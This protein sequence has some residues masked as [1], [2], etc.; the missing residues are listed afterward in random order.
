[1]VVRTLQ[2][3]NHSETA[4]PAQWAAV[5]LGSNLGDRDAFLAFARRRLREAGFGWTL[6]SPI[7]ETAPVGGPSGQGAY[8]NQAL[9]AP[10]GGLR[11]S[12]RELLAAALAIESEAGRRRDERWGPRTLDVDLL[13]YGDCVID[14]PDLAVPHPRLAGRRFVLAPL[15]AIVPDAVHPGLGATVAELLARLDPACP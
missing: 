3:V 13:L 2:G 8:L 9:A 14:E 10:L 15:A 4:R 7:V 1:M 11:L 5:S 6:A 12:P